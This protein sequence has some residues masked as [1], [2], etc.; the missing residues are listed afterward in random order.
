MKARHH[1]T[2]RGDLAVRIWSLPDRAAFA[3]IATLSAVAILSG[4]MPAAATDMLAAP[5]HEPAPV[6]S[7]YDWTGGYVGVSAGWSVGSDQTIEYINN[8]YLQ[9]FD[10]TPNGFLAGVYGGYNYQMSNVVVGVELDGLM[11]SIES[12]FVDPPFGTP[13]P[14][15]PGA[16]GDIRLNWTSSARL[17][18]G[19][20][21]DD[22]RDRWR[23]ARPSLGHLRQSD[24]GRRPAGL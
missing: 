1:M 11:S 5:I 7:A 17:R 6:P 14:G 3:A 9:D 22:L 21:L 4:A 20:A 23:R 15:D 16:T 10:L 24:A 2:Q 19:F 12:G 8:V 18:L 13:F